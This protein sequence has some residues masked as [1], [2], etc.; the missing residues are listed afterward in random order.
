[1]QSILG[2]TRKADITFHHTGRICIS[3]RIAKTLG[4]AH[5]DV[6]DIIK[7]EQRSR[8]EY[9]M[10]IKHRDAVGKHEGMVF[11]SNKNGRHYIASSIK[12]SRYIM[13][14]CGVSDRVRLCC[15]DPIT[16]PLYGT[17]VPIIIKHCLN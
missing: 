12:L 16:I 9:Y 5:H 11:R 2:S 4:L 14:Q 10:V 1:M 3:A 15:G 7:D 6:I 17:A 13:Q 8:N